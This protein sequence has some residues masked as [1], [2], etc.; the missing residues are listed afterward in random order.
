MKHPLTEFLKNSITVFWEL[1]YEQLTVILRREPTSV[2]ELRIDAGRAGWQLCKVQNIR[3]TCLFTF[4]KGLP[5]P[6]RRSVF[7]R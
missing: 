7:R 2:E 4:K 6:P 3:G 5:Q 1:T